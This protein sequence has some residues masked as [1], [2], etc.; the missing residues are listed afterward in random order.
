MCMS[1]ALV[2][3]FACNSRILFDE[4]LGGY[5]WPYAVDCQV[6]A[7]LCSIGVAVVNCGILGRLSLDWIFCDTPI[8]HNNFLA[9][10]ATPTSPPTQ[11]PTP[12]IHSPPVPPTP[13][14]TS[15]P[16]PLIHY[17]LCPTSGY[18]TIGAVD[19]TGLHCC[20]IGD[21]DPFVA[22]GVN[23]LFWKNIMSCEWDYDVACSCSSRA[24]E[25]LLLLLC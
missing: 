17:G 8:L 20:N 24:S 25:F 15:P 3:A 19:C 1:G 10:C 2:G 7:E 4:S 6:S 5:Y 23:T 22:C 18:N 11:P 21:L 12:P 13:P 16:T 9:Q 14:P